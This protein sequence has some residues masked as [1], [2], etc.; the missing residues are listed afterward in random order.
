MS[1]VVKQ[2]RVDGRWFDRNFPKLPDVTGRVGRYKRGR[3]LVVGIGATANSDGTVSFSMRLRPKP[4]WYLYRMDR[5][6]KKPRGRFEAHAA[7]DVRK[8]LKMLTVAQRK[9]GAA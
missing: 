6:D 8:V 7:C 1:D 2:F 4:T 5:L 3:F 9:A